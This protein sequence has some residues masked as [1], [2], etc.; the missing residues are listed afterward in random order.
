[1]LYFPG[2]FCIYLNQLSGDIGFFNGSTIHLSAT[3]GD[4]IM[5]AFQNYAH[6][7]QIVKIQTAISSG[8]SDPAEI[9][10]TVHLPGSHRSVAASLPDTGD[11]PAEVEVEFQSE[12][13]WS[14]H[15]TEYMP[16][17]RLVSDQSPGTEPGSSVTEYSHFR[18]WHR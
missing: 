12:G 5:C 3:A 14:H 11:V 17:R 18:Q 8:I 16:N 1:M 2:I 10:I 9:R 4:K 6:S 15:L 7:F 13:E